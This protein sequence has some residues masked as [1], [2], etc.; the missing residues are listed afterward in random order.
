MRFATAATGRCSDESDANQEYATVQGVATEF[1]LEPTAEVPLASTR[2]IFSLSYDDMRMAGELK[3]MM[4]Q[5]FLAIRGL[6]AVRQLSFWILFATR[7]GTLLLMRQKK[8]VEALGGG[9]VLERSAWL[10]EA[11][12]PGPDK[13][14]WWLTGVKWSTL[15]SVAASAARGHEK[16]C[17]SQS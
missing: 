4:G 5:S 1:L 14:F 7:V 6:N 10:G 16:L 8:Q 13:S 12:H 15:L 9:R 11:A 2:E 3:I 17:P